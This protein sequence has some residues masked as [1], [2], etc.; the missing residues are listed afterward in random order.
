MPGVQGFPSAILGLC[1]FLKGNFVIKADWLEVLLLMTFKLYVIFIFSGGNE[2]Y[3][4]ICGMNP[5]RGWR[6]GF[7]DSAQL[8]LARCEL[9]YGHL[10]VSLL[11]LGKRI[12]EG[13]KK[14]LQETV[15]VFKHTQRHACMSIGFLD[16]GSYP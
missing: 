14:S 7:S 11:G 9:T 5:L 6:E 8:L 13:R 2:K 3:F 1:K 16:V 12:K 10:V 4:D 15:C